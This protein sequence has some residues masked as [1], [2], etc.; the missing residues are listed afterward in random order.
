MWG[1][2][3]REEERGARA[4]AKADPARRQS[5]SGV[6]RLFGIRQQ[7]VDATFHRD[8]LLPAASKARWCC[9]FYTP[10]PQGSQRPTSALM[11]ASRQGLHPVMASGLKC[12]PAELATTSSGATPA[13]MEN[14]AIEHL[15][16]PIWG[17][18]RLT[19]KPVPPTPLCNSIVAAF[20]L[21]AASTMAKPSPLP[22][23]TL[24]LSCSIDTRAA[25]YCSAPG[26]CAGLAAAIALPR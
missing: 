26:V 7:P 6:A 23:N 1:A 5:R 10:P 18:Q 11:S 12:S 20:R 24:G 3:S 16:G 21:A 15:D 2:G 25:S 4:S 13:Q 14:G 22:A 17:G 8:L 9:R 19:A